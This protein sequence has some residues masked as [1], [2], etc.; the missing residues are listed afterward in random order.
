MIARQPSREIP[1]H[2]EMTKVIGG[3][4]HASIR[5]YPRTIGEPWSRDEQDTFSKP[6]TGGCWSRELF[7]VYL[8][9]LDGSS[10]AVL[11][12]LMKGILAGEM[13]RP[14]NNLYWRLYFP[15]KRYQKPCPKLCVA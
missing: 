14:L 4:I 6:L 8:P 12:E 10:S 11:L 13:K 3:G 15:K 5:S 2:K 9:A 1:F 7:H